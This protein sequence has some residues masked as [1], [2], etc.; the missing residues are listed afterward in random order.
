MRRQTRASYP[1]V[2][3]A[4]TPGAGTRCLRRGRSQA[5]RAGRSRLEVTR[6]NSLVD[7]RAIDTRG[8]SFAIA[9]STFRATGSGW[10]P[11]RHA[12]LVSPVETWFPP[13]RRSP[14]T[15]AITREPRSVRAY[16]MR[17][18]AYSDAMDYRRAIRDAGAAIRLDPTCPGVSGSVMPGS[19]SPTSRHAGRCRR[20]RPTRSKLGACLSVP[21]R[22]LAG[23]G[24]V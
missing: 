13:I 2:S 9:S 7:G 21:R 10:S 24:A 16:R 19:R 5:H 14:S 6:H 20:G 8:D 17:G 3:V 15:A 12:R 11:T 22:R 1:G 23:K 18:F 4:R